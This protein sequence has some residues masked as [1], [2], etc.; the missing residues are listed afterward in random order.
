MPTVDFVF[1]LDDDSYLHIP[2]LVELL[3][4]LGDRYRK[5][6]REEEERI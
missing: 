2:R 5:E 1:Y 4:S 3:T 6:A